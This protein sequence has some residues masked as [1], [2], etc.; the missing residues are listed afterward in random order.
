MK[1]RHYTYASAILASC[2]A[3]GILFPRR[4]PS[5]YERLSKLYGDSAEYF[6]QL[7]TAEQAILYSDTSDYMSARY[8]TA[9]IE[10]EWFKNE[11]D[12]YLDSAVKY[13]ELKGREQFQK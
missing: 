10:C 11:H 5:P 4:Q 1:Q 8:E 2:I 9:N 6:W 13:L 7:D 12:R 3:I